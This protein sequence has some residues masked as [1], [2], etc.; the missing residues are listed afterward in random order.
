MKLNGFPGLLLLPITYFVSSNTCIDFD[1]RDYIN[2]HSLSCLCDGINTVIT[3][4][5][6][7]K[8]CRPG[9]LLQVMDFWE[10]SQGLSLL[11]ILGVVFVLL[12]MLLILNRLII[13]RF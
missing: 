4:E 7:Y 5:F 8:A 1:K 10:E 9:V 6:Y 3:S 2:L 13:Q 11:N 12:I